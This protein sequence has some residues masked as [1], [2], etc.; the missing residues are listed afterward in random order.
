MGS[1]DDNAADSPSAD[2]TDPSLYDEDGVLYGGYEDEETW[3]EMSGE[4]TP[5]TASSPTSE[6]SRVPLLMVC[7]PELPANAAAEVE[8]ICASRRAATCLNVNSESLS[9]SL[10]LCGDRNQTTAPVEEGILW[11]TGY[12]NANPPASMD[13]N[14]ETS[15]CVEI[16]SVARYVGL[17]CAC[18]STVMAS[19]KPNK[20]S[21]MNEAANV[22]NF[23][24][25]DIL[26]KMID[27]SINNAKGKDEMSS[28]FTIGDVLNVRLYYKA[29]SNRN[30]I[31]AL[32]VLAEMTDRPTFQHTLL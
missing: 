17:G 18:V 5:S 28:L 30:N 6:K 19:L 4:E 1:V 3:R 20:G 29:A 22:F 27:K 9:R 8:L 26:S 10:V 11:D 25:E 31:T 23:D 12:D 32:P 15:S 2:N 16:S 21:S 7:L 14:Q 13:R 24:V